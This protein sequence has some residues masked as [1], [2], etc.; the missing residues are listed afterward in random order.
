MK[1]YI[2]IDISKHRLDVDWLGKSVAFAN[3][4]VGLNDLVEQ[5]HILQKINMGYYYF[6]IFPN[7]IFP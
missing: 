7:Y 4:S 2:G 5:L 3:D 1:D 6:H